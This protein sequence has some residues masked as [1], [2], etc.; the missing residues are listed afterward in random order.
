MSVRRRESLDAYIKAWTNVPSIARSDIDI[1]KIAH[2]TAQLA[3]GNPNIRLPAIHKE[4]FN[5]T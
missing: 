2:W 3:S 5:E 4:L 1:T